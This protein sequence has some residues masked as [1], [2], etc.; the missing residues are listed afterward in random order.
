MSTF[1]VSTTIQPPRTEVWNI[2]ADIGTIAAWNPG[3]VE[4]ILL[5]T[6]AIAVAMALAQ[7]ATVIWAATTIWMSRLSSGNR[8]SV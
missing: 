4:S 2:L 3:V 8:S 7:P 6:M 5:L 1:A